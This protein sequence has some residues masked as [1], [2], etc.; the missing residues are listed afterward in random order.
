MAAALAGVESSDF[1]VPEG[2]KCVHIDP[3][4]GIRALAGGEAIL[5]C[6][7]AGTEPRLGSVPAVQLIGRDQAAEP[8]VLDFLRS[9]F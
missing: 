3:A 5:E 7:R 8:S 4:T 9:D 6:F 1:A 2:L